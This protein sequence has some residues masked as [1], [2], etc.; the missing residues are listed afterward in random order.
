[1]AADP[2][3]KALRR[4][5]LRLGTGE[6]AA[7]AVLVYFAGY[8]TPRLQSPLDAIALW[9]AVIPLLAVLVQ[10][11]LYWLR[12][13][14]W[15]QRAAMPPELAALYR[16]LRVAN[17]FLLALGLV[18]IIVWWPD[19]LAGALAVLAVWI[20][21]LVEYLNYFIVRLSYPLKEWFSKVGQRRIPTLAQDIAR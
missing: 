7:S 9:S 10:A 21:A 1:M 8:V 17:V 16:R 4:R 19:H 12:A 20:F 18:G 6:L 13:R 2:Q 5:Y 14:A 3:L 15:V 11:G